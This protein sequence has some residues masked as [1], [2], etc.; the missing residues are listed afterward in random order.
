MVASRS[1]C[2]GSQ[3]GQRR[4]G[5][6]GWEGH[7]QSDQSPVCKVGQLDWGGGGGTTTS[8]ALDGGSLCR[9]SNLSFVTCPMAP[10]RR[11]YVPC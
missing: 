10:K 3:S 5:E 6:E 1:N 9:M 7:G 4:H 11:P 8:G 2:T